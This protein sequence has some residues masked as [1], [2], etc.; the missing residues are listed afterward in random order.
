MACDAQYWTFPTSLAAIIILRIMRW[1]VHGCKY[2]Y[3]CRFGVL[4]LDNAVRI[5]AATKVGTRNR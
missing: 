1:Y 5:L 2:E 4:K 3:A